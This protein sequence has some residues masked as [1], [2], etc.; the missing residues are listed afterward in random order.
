M[1]KTTKAAAPQKNTITRD[2]RLTFD[3]DI[4]ES[5]AVKAFIEREARRLNTSG[6][7]GYLVQL[8]TAAMLA[9]QGD[10]T[11][12][13]MFAPSAGSA[14]VPAPAQAAPAAPST[15][16]GEQVNTAAIAASLSSVF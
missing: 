7:A 6:V 3:Q 9:Q 11:L 16:P 8:A 12:A 1:R 10:M 14:L 5:M 13:G 4:P 2:V 15:A